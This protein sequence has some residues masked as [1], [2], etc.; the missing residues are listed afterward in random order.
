MAIAL[1]AVAE[2]VLVKYP[3]SREL[4]VARLIT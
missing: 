2:D 3:T 4:Q 1:T